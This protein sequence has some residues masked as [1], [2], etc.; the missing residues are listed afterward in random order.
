MRYQEMYHEADAERKKLKASGD[1]V[2]RLTSHL[3]MLEAALQVIMKHDLLSELATEHCRLQDAV[4]V[5]NGE[6]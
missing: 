3:V 1:A 2:S 4:A 6:S 5:P